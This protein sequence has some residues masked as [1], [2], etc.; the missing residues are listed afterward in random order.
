MPNGIIGYILQK[1]LKSKGK[2]V[3]SIYKT[4]AFC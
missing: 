2:D 4:P 3:K 1:C